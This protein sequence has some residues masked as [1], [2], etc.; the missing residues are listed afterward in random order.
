MNTSSRANG[1]SHEWYP[2]AM[3]HLVH[4][5]LD[6]SP[7][8][9]SPF[10]EHLSAIAGGSDLRVAC[11]YL[12]LA[13]LEPILNRA[14]SWRLLTDAE[15][16]V[17]SLVGAQRAEIVRFLV[18]HGER[19]RHWPDLH[20]KVV[21]GDSR[22]LVGSANLTAMGLGRRQEMAVAFED[23]GEVEQLRGWFDALWQRCTAPSPEELEAFR[24]SLPEEPPDAEHGAH[25]QPGSSDL[26]DCHR[27]PRTSGRHR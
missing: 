15:A 6:A 25:L 20:A 21:V 14:R 23:C 5:A 10:V 2:R 22:A 7:E 26:S 4:H 9:L 19:V 24:A 16:L 3:L 8:T 12:G 27:T 18:E 1:S 17:K 11:P 13:V